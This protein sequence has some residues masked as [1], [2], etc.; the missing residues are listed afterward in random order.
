[1]ERRTPREKK[2]L[3]YLKDGRNEYGE[4]DKSS[5]RNVRL[6]KRAPNSANR[7]RARTALAALLGPPDGVRA[8]AAEERLTGR[9]P[10]RWRKF[11][12]APLGVVVDGALQRRAETD[13]AG[14]G[15]A[16]ARLRRVRSRFDWASRADD[17]LLPPHE[18][19]RVR[20][21]PAGDGAA[22]RA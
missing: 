22:D 21:A 20:S 19:R 8:G 13:P 6:N 10:K 17:P 11:P 9:R 4:N 18:V 3:S 1:M 14:A 7:R 2:R 15:R 12:D 16:A 5:R